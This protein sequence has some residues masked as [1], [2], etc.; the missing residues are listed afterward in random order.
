MFGDLDEYTFTPEENKDDDDSEDDKTFQRW[1]EIA[2]DEELF[3][4]V[5]ECSQ[6][7][8]DGNFTDNSDGSVDL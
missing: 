2:N 7:T 4:L 1:N 8:L 6:L 3:G 5:L